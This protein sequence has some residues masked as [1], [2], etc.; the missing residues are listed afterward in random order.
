MKHYE[1]LSDI[2]AVV[3]GFETCT[4]AKDDFTHVHHLTVAVFYL[5]NANETKAIEKMRTALLRFLN[6]HGVGQMKYHETLTVFW[7]KMLR[8]F[9]IELD[10]QA[11]LV[12]MTNSSVERFCDS[13]LVA[14]YYSDEV[15]K[16]AEA[17]NSWVEPDLKLIP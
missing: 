13:R 4:T 11:S 7:I 17:R 10:S 8:A 6:H 15:L 3:R 16:S 2:E 1:Q 9:L 5:F 12:E 14:D